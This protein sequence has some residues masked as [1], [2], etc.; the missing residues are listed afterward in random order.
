MSADEGHQQPE[1]HF[2]YL[3]EALLLQ[4]TSVLS[5]PANLAAWL[6]ATGMAASDAT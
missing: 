4:S 3:F 1:S 6:C 2:Y 5:Y